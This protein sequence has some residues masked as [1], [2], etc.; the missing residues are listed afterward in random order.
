MYHPSYTGHGALVPQHFREIERLD[1]GLYQNRKDSA[2]TC[3]ETLGEMFLLDQACTGMPFT[4]VRLIAHTPFRCDLERHTAHMFTV[5][6]EDQ[7]QVSWERDLTVKVK[8]VNKPML[9]IARYYWGSDMN[10]TYK[11]FV[12]RPIK[13]E[14]HYGFLRDGGH[15]GLSFV[16]LSLFS[17]WSFLQT[18]GLLLHDIMKYE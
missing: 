2:M 9:E 18:D 11:R 1:I 7:V 13:L 15:C 5:D 10:D 12:D 8:E 3:I 17:C 14:P 16:K 4:Q 6:C